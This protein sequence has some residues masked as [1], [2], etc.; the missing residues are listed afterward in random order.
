MKVPGSRIPNQASEVQTSSNQPEIVCPVIRGMVNDGHLHVDAKGNANISELKD[1]FEDLGFNRNLAHVA[2][3]GNGIG[4][5]VGNL[6]NGKFNVNQLRGGLLDHSGD[7]MI[8]RNGKF[9]PERFNALV[10][11]SSDGV[12]MTAADFQKAIQ[13]NKKID[14][15]SWIGSRISG[16][17]FSI[18]MDAFGTKGADGVKGISIED[19]R[20]LYENKNIPASFRPTEGVRPENNVAGLASQVRNLASGSQVGMAKAGVDSALQSSDLF[21]SGNIAVQGAGKGIC[22]HMSAAGTQT[23]P[24]SAQEV[25]QLHN[26]LTP[27]AE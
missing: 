26:Q 11:H 12:R 1:I 6:W 14:D 10:A 18:L 23:T 22:P 19:L 20:N 15:A 2:A 7:S 5:I 24:A 21:T 9:D 3:V 17:E 13:D 4:D 16:V 25:T 8:L 27:R